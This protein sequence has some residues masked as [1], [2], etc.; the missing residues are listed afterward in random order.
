MYG[1]TNYGNLFS[2]NFTEWLIRSG[3]VKSQ[4][5][6]SIYYKYASDGTKIIVLFFVDDCVY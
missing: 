3:F 4:C 5:Q 1:M 2:N 6:I